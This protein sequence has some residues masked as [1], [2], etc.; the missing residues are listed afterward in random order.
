M[1]EMTLTALKVAPNKMELREF[2]IPE[3]DEDSALMKVEVAGV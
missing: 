3:I 2:P 1:A